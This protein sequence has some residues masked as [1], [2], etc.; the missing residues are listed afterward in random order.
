MHSLA[1]LLLAFAATPTDRTDVQVHVSDQVTR[2]FVGCN[3]ELL[4]IEARKPGNR[5]GANA[6]AASSCDAKLDNHEWRPRYHFAAAVIDSVR[7]D[8]Q[9]FTGC[10]LLHVATML[11]TGP[12]VTVL[13]LDCR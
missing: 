2:Y 5:A 10:R 1:L 6:I 3:L 7:L 12:R 9:S 11:S 8:G 4:N 13:Q